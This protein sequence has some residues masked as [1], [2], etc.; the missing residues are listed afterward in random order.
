MRQ[1]EHV[2]YITLIDFLLQLLFLG[3][4]LSVIYYASQPDTNQLDEMRADARQASQL[5]KL[6]GI[7]NFTELTD[8]L[9]RLGPLREARRDLEEY[10]KI[11]DTVKKI[12]GVESVSKVLTSHVSKIGQGR[13]SCLENG[14]K[15]T[16]FDA[17]VDRIEHRGKI[18]S[19]FIKILNENNIDS[20]K[21]TSMSLDEFKIIFSTIDSSSRKK[22][23]IYNVNLIE[24]S[25][26]TKPRDAV[27]A[28]FSPNI[29]KAPDAK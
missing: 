4:V 15:L 25:Y 11:S 29:T 21:I 18:S 2:L 26:N 20:E 13:P 7:S 10:R 27:R 17:F 8:E 16:T 24:H 22:E 3:L 5:K 28:I 9:T 14:A 19:E 1:T 23:C 6:T 12:G